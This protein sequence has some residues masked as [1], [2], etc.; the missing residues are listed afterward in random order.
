MASSVNQSV[1]PVP[2]GDCWRMMPIGIKPW[3]KLLPVTLQLM[4]RSL[5]AVMI[6]LC[7]LGDGR[8]LWGKY[9]ESFAENVLL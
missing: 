4:Q 2:R 7:G 3:E 5:F 8:R 6:V 1:K 9:K